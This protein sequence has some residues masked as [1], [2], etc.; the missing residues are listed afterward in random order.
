M[1]PTAA[2][3]INRCWRHIFEALRPVPTLLRDDMPADRV[4]SIPGPDDPDVHDR[5]EMGSQLIGKVG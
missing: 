5:P 4:A 1:L 2:S 3:S